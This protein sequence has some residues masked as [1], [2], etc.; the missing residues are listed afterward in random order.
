ME[1][2]SPANVQ[3][4]QILHASVLMYAMISFVSSVILTRV[5]VSAFL[6]A[7]VQT[8]QIPHVNAQMDQMRL[9]KEINVQMEQI[10]LVNV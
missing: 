2:I 4:G 10:L 6:I 9:A 5:N 8:D 1:Q 7:N 3:T